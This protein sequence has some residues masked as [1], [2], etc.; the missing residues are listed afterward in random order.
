[1]REPAS[2]LMTLLVLLTDTT[3]AV[4]TPL[5]AHH[6]ISLSTPFRAAEIGTSLR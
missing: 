6:R 2:F 1:M 4:P 5:T 3:A